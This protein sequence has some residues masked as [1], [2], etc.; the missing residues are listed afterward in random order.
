[1]CPVFML[2][3]LKK[4]SHNMYLWH[5]KHIKVYFLHFYKKK[6]LKMFVDSKNSC[7]LAHKLRTILE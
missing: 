3:R 4:V 2:T 5:K 7:N 1:M 6:T